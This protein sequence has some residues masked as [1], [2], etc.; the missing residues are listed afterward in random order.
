MRLRLLITFLAIS[1]S[2]LLAEE[3]EINWT[4]R[5][6]TVQAEGAEMQR[7][8]F[9]DGKT[10][11]GLSLDAE[12]IVTAAEGGAKLAYKRV[13]S[14]SFT[15]RDAVEKLPLPPDPKKIE[16]YR[17]AA[18]S[19]GAEGASDFSDLQEQIDSLSINDWRSYRLDF[20]YNF[21]GQRHR[22]SVTYLT[23]PNG[24]QAVL[25]TDALEGEF[26]QAIARSDHLIRTW[27]VLPAAGAI[28]PRS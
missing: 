11:Y 5:F 22:R 12:T 7:V 14:A 8:F 16:D 3:K 10:R 23:F 4:P 15:I 18:L 25:T 24:Q 9:T 20:T 19:I 28:A 2:S 6:I 1:A 27:H 21:F 13:P 17:R 26:A